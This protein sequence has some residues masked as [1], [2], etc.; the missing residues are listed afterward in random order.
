MN[1]FFIN[2]KHK[3]NIAILAATNAQFS[4]VLKTGSTQ[5]HAP[6]DGDQIHF[7]CETSSSVHTWGLSTFLFKVTSS[8]PYTGQQLYPA[9]D[10]SSNT[11]SCWYSLTGYD[12]T[13]NQIIISDAKYTVTCTRDELFML[14]Y[15]LK[16]I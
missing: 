9:G 4:S 3:I 11:A 2:L 15:M 10:I 7:G 5:F 14:Q 8:T 12:E 16:L 6:L 13:S 1:E